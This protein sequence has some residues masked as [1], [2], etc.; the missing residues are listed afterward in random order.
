MFEFESLDVCGI[1]RQAGI[2]FDPPEPV[3]FY[4]DCAHTAARGFSDDQMPCPLCKITQLEASSQEQESRE[5][6]AS[7]AAMPG[8]SIGA[9]KVRTLDGPL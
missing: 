7:V 2:E 3:V 5:Q 4:I 8:P 1:C 9:M 6:P